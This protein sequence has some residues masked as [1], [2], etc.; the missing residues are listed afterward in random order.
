MNPFNFIQKKIRALVGNP[1][2]NSAFVAREGGGLLIIR[3][4]YKGLNFLTAV[5][6]ARILH[7]T[8]YGE[9]T[10]V[11]SWAAVLAIPA[12]LGIDRFGA[13]EIA[14]YQIKENWGGLREFLSWAFRSVLA[15]ASLSALA[16]IAVTALIYADDPGMRLAFWLSGGL[17][18]CTALVRLLQASSEGLK[19]ISLGRIPDMLIQPAMLVTILL[20][21]Y[22]LAPSLL[23]APYAV[24]MYA[25]TTLIFS[26]G[27]GSVILWRR[28]P[29]RALVSAPKTD[30]PNWLK[31]AV[32]FILISAIFVADT[33][34]STLLL[35]A[36]MP[37]SQ[38]AIFDTL[39][40]GTDLITFIVTAIGVPLGRVALQFYLQN[41]K[42]RLQRALTRG[43]WTI[44]ALAAPIALGL[45]VFGKWYLL[46]FG[47]E[48][49]AGYNALIIL[50]CGEF[51]AIGSGIV[52]IL[53]TMTGYEKI[54][55]RTL[56]AA[57]TLNLTLGVILIPHI[58][59]LGAA[60]AEASSTA[61]RNIVLAIFA[62]KKLGVNATIFARLKPKP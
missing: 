36:L 29:R 37:K 15:A 21:T 46:L 5:L 39:T 40:R 22:W 34:A 42:E 53:M 10:Y 55:A 7:L 51:F 3:I 57:L 41:N 17:L 31:M 50:A 26:I 47:E 25:L 12:L 30:H 4:A 60:I 58:G 9:Y 43:T 54:T 33:R 48:Y 11:M 35:G 16:L 2:S 52:G 8:E 18:I 20:G 27:I 13:R 45:I 6:L 62:W 32:P 44:V 14:K 23:S 28:L 49:L 61:F 56:V 38:V 59:I 1:D 24:G 19:V